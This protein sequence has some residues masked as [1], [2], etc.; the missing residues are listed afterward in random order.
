MV[1]LFDD[2]DDDDDD[3][4]NYNDDKDP[5]VDD[6]DAADVNAVASEV[7]LLAASAI[8]NSDGIQSD[9]NSSESNVD[10]DGKGLWSVQ[11]KPFV[12]TRSTKHS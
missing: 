2:D 10:D 7:V 3:D 5:D 9:T 4:S 8:L 1:K 6:G 11:P 12:S